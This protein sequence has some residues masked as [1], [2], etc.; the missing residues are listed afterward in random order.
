M[1]IQVGHGTLPDPPHPVEIQTPLDKKMH[2]RHR[3]LKLQF[4]YLHFE[5]VPLFA[6]PHVVAH[7]F[8]YGDKSIM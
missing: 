6:T 8:I 4:S 1:H 3:R 7:P 5:T 2:I